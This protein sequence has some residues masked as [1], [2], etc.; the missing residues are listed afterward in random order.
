MLSDHQGR[1]LNMGKESGARKV[2]I[3]NEYCCIDIDAAAPARRAAAQ[4]RPGRE[5][6]FPARFN[7]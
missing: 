1:N 4:K 3:C 5:L 7:T 6:A 2:T